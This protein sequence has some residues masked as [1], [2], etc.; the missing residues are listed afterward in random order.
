MRIL[1]VEDDSETAENI[2]EGLSYAGHSAMFVS[3][4]DTGLKIATTRQF[5]ILIIDR[6]LPGMDGLSLIKALRGANIETPVLCLTALDGIEDRVLGLEAGADDY[7]AKPF[8]FSELLARVNAV[9]RRSNRNQ[10]ETV[11]RVGDL[12]LD[13]ITRKV[14]RGGK[15]IELLPREFA[16]LELL[17]QHSGRVVTRA[18]LL[19]HVWGF[20]FEP[21]TS[22]VDTHMS[23]LRR[24]IDKPFDVS[25][26]QTIRGKGYRLDSEN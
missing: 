17:A 10:T 24:K 8:G 13:R 6:M 18:M 5:D 16:M 1:V 2:V 15:P 9:T 19:K 4:G 22:L 14:T 12:E 25:M 26:L 20:N 23:R 11:I 7:L 3:R 21:K